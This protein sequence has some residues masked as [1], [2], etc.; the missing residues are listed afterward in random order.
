MIRFK[1]ATRCR[2]RSDSF[3][4]VELLAVMAIIAILA[5]V[6]LGAGNGVFIKGMR[7]R[8]S[9]E[10]AAISSAAEGYKTDNGIYPQ[11]DGLL[12]TNY[13]SAD[14]S[15]SGDEYQV[16]SQTLFQCL[17]SELNL[18]GPVIN[19][20]P[21]TGKIYMSF[22]ANQVGNPST[23]NS[24]IMDPWKQSY[25]YST[26]TTNGAPSPSYPYNGSGFFDLWTTAG[27]KVGNTNLNIWISNW[28]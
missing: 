23:G 3:T 2:Q 11:S 20:A 15:V 8:A 10:I 5:A 7:S 14:G 27:T 26:G 22:K 6:I 24:Y 19:T 4:L 16:N 1:S 17:A 9:T 25:G 18:G 28:Q 13:T 12:L 21:C